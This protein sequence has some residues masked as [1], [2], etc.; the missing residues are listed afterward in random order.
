[1]ENK[2]HC[3]VSAVLCVPWTVRV[4]NL[5]FF[6]FDTCFSVCFQSQTGGGARRQH[7]YAA[8]QD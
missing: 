8:K 3:N 6:V 2:E 5:L 4:L 7:D 1:M